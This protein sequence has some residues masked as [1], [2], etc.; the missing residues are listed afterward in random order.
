MAVSG[1][2]AA[3]E[4]RTEEATTYEAAMESPDANEWKKAMEQEV[5]ALEENHT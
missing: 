5:A 3:R 4:V 2:Q 1:R